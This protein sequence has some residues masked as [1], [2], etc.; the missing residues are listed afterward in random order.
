MVEKKQLAEEVVICNKCNDK[1]S[2]KKPNYIPTS[3]KCG[4]IKC[5][6]TPYYIRTLFIDSNKNQITYL[7]DNVKQ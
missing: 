1:F 3:C 2:T 6:V 5:D 7:V 4:A